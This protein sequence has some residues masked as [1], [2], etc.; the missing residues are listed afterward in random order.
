MVSQLPYQRMLE[1]CLKGELRVL[2]AHL[3]RQQKLLSDLLAEEHPHVDCND[4]STHFFKRKELEYLASITGADEQKALLLPILI[5][6]GPN[7]GEV[8][9]ICEPGI[10]EKIV[11]KILNMPIICE[12]GRITLYRPQL[13]VLRKVLKTTTQYVFSSRTLK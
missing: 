3:P 7:Q 1:E 4:G 8:S 2:N 11:V 5:E 12:Q 10:T 9:I 13:G 6:L